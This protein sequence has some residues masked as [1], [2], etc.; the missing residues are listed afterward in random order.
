MNY[1]EFTDKEKESQIIANEFY[2]ISNWQYDRT[3]SCK[4]YD[5]LIEGYKIEEKFRYI[6]YNDFLIEIVQ[7]VITQNM[8]WYYKTTCDRVFYW[9]C[10]TKLYTVNWPALKKWLKDEYK[11]VKYKG[12]IS[13]DGYGLTINISISWHDIPAHLYKTFEL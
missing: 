7:D 1:N 4:E 9:V 13:A 2:E 3:L 6:D 5:L 10:D 8:G 12:V 11:T